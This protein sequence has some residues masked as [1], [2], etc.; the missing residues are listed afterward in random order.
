MR[1]I[2]GTTVRHGEKPYTSEAETSVFQAWVVQPAQVAF[3]YR[4]QRKCATVV[5]Q[6]PTPESTLAGTMNA[7]LEAQAASHKRS[8]KALSFNLAARLTELGMDR[9][10]QDVLPSEE[11]LAVFEAA[12]R[13][14]RE[15][16][17]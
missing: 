14:A 12:G 8:V 4:V 6:A 2:I 7:Y 9:F 1:E 17:R 16:G 5:P 11:N 10:P 13:I 3:A 15:K